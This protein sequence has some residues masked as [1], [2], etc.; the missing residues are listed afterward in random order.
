[1]NR[2]ILFFLLLFS[3]LNSAFSQGVQE[4]EVKGKVT[5]FEGTPIDSALVSLY[6]SDFSPAYTVYS[7]QDGNYKLTGVKKGT[8]LAMYVL[9]PEEYPRRN[10]VAPEDMR[11]E[12]WAWNV[13]VDE[14][15]TINP[16]YHR[17]EL[18]GLN[19]FTVN[20]GG[21][22]LWL[23]VRPM[24]LGKLIKYES[25]I[26]TDKAKLEKKVDINVYPEHFKAE[27][28]IDDKQVEVKSMQKI[29]ELPAN[30]SGAAVVGYMINVD[31]KPSNS[32]EKP[33]VIK[34]V[35]ENT[36]FN[37]KGE[38]ILFY[39]YGNYEFKK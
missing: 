32:R 1:M 27:V 25:D 5:D 28:F 30:E 16:R 7:D 22:R 19:A 36:E 26:Y 35:G 17:L 6:Y 15:L 11:L 4:F 39:K 12:F 21:S 23:Y 2:F 9:R 3:S 13:I 20:G 38:N 37:E 18:Y 8:Y 33:Y 31:F 29:E 34:V 24:S 10:A 14:N